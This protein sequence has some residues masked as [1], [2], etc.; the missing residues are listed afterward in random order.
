MAGVS[1]GCARDGARKA[2]GGRGPTNPEDDHDFGTVLFVT[3]GGE[4][5]GAAAR[6]GAGDL[7]CCRHC[8]LSKRRILFGW[9]G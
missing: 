6:Q 2:A 9:G 8:A 5:E 7:A 1:R 3:L 4:I